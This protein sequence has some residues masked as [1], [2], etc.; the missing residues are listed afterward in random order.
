MSDPL[1]A[2]V[3]KSRKAPKQVRRLLRAGRRPLLR[4]G[5]RRHGPAVHRHARRH[6]RD[7][8]DRPGR[9]IQPACDQPR[10][11]PRTSTAAVAHRPARPAAT[12]RR[13]VSMNGERFAVMAGAGF[14]ADMIARRGRRAQGPARPRR[15]HLDGGEEPPHAAVPGQD[16]RR[17]Q[18]LVQR[19][20]ELHPGRERR[21]AVRRRAGVRRRRAGRR[22]ARP[23]GDHRRR[24][25]RVG[26]H[27]WPH[28]RRQPRA[29]TALPDRP[30]PAGSR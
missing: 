18:P 1:W 13:R 27:G 6:R 10:A 19:R 9:D 16:P 24:R 15:L 5:R 2:E 23:G 14:D 29:L 11:S 25:R 4:L 30:R 22:P 17:R 3:P 26:G 8:R 7:G 12:D 20:R 28:D 21:R